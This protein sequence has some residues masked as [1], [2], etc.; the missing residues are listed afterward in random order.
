M[1]ST[2]PPSRP[3]D[4]GPIPNTAAITQPGNNGYVYHH[5]KSAVVFA[6]VVNLV[7]AS[8]KLFVGT[9]I[10]QSATLFSEGLHS[11]ADG[12]NSVTLLIG[13]TRGNREPDRTHPFGYGLEANLWALFAALFLIISSLWAIYSG[14]ME[15]LE[16]SGFSNFYWAAG[17]LL[18]SI[19]LEV[20]AVKNASYAVLEEVGIEIKGWNAILAAFGQIKNVI[21]P[22]TRFVFYED[23]LALCGA[24]VAL[25]ALSISHLSVLNGLVEVGGL[26]DGIGSII[27]GLLML[28]LAFRLV[29]DNQGVLTA[30]A[31]PVLVEEKI[32]TLATAVHGVSQAYDIKSMDQG[33]S[34]L[35]V[36]MKIEVDPDTQVKDV[37]DLIDRVKERIQ[38]KIPTVRQV[39]IEV[40]ADESEENWSERFYEILA[41]GRSE[42]VIKPREETMLRKVYEFSESVARDIMVPRTDV[43]YVE[44]QTPLSEVADL[45]VETGHSRI[46]VYKEHIDDLAGVVHARDLFEMLKESNLDLPL[47]DVIREVDIYPENK[48][49][50]DLLEDFKRK[51]I[52]IAAVADEHG[53]FAGIITIEDL[54]E[55]IV[56]E[57]YDEHDEEEKL[58]EYIDANR[59]LLN[60]KHEIEDLNEAFN[61]NIPTDEFKTVG[62]YV[63]GQLGREPELGDK[64]QFEDLTLEVTEAEGPRII[65][66]TLESPTPLKAV[67]EDGEPS[68]LDGSSNPDA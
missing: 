42:G 20:F 21:G 46:P 48:P 43:E 41:Q 22:T 13:I 26:A 66:V 49:I 12:V 40:L 34:G 27:I 37:D 4:F 23:T 56:G 28:V 9:M 30:S 38:T 16:P 7:I 25:S 31:A 36:H 1:A 32:Q 17:I 55:E 6:L 62:G 29:R 63:F 54:M 19:V 14:V 45:I 53:G 11:L 39:F 61:L 3:S 51:K 47:S 15:T 59:V 2:E 18:V 57:I 64:V 5:A 35:I 60:G 58:L 68:P 33:I 52:Q 44:L 10:V 65:T 50:S 8:L 67:S 24:I